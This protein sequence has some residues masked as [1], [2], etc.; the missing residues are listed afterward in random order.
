[1]KV[2]VIT[3][4]C[5]SDYHIVAVT[6]DEDN[7]KRF[8]D[9]G[10]GDIEEFETDECILPKGML[11]YRVV[12]D[13]DGC[14]WPC[15]VNEFFFDNSYKE[16]LKEGLKEG[17]IAPNGNFVWSGFARDK[18][19]ALKIARDYRAKKLAEMYNL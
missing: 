19:H 10:L 12:I 13:K 9:A 8:V 3:D 5:Y 6:L 1:M 4:G 14:V 16:G 18:D 17:K 11:P 7:A 15:Y 2:Y